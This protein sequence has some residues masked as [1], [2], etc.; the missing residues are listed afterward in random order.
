MALTPAQLITLKAAIAAETDPTFVANRTA[1]ATGAMA[2]FYNTDSAVTVW[3]SFTTVD[4]LFNA[5][6]WANLTPVD[7]ADSTQLWMNRALA[8]Q[9]KQFNLQTL[10]AG[11]TTLNTGFVNIRNGLQDALTNLP[12]GAAGAIIAAGWVNGVRL[13]VQRLAKRGEALFAAGGAGTPATPHDLVFEGTVS[14]NDI[15][16]ALAS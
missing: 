11:R 5:I 10:L 12:T 6:A 15:I 4:T 2:A 16:L 7:A 3:R 14:N 8:A 9:S 13:A 1:G